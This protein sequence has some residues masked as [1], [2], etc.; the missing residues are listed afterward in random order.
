MNG[1]GKTPIK[2]GTDGWRGIIADD[3]TFENVRLCAQATADYLAAQNSGDRVVTV[4]YDTRF[5]SAG[6][7][8]AVC[9]VLAG[10]G[11]KCLL[12]ES[13]CPT[14]ALSLATAYN[15]ASAGIVITASHNPANWNGFKL[16]SPDGSSASGDMVASVEHQVELNLEE[17]SVKEVLYE[18]AA[19]SGLINVTDFKTPYLERLGEMV[20]LESIKASKLKIFYDAMY[21][22]GTGYLDR[23]I[24]G[25]NLEFTP[26]NN[27]VNPAFPG[28]IQPEPIARNLEKLS[29][30]VNQSGASAGLATDGDADRLGVV[31]E[32][33]VFL[34]TLQVYALLVLYLLEIK[35]ERGAIVRTI[36]SSSMLD[37][38]GEMYGVPVIEVPVGFKY[39][40]PV[41]IK[42]NAMVGGEESGGYGYRGHVPERDGILSALYFLDLMAR[43]G[44]APSGLLRLLFSKVGAHYYDRV[45]IEYPQGARDEIYAR[46]QKFEPQEL[47]G[48][49]IAGK[50]NLDGFRFRLEDGS[51]L[52]VRFSGTEPL[53][54]IYS[55]AGTR[56]RVERLLKIGREITHLKGMEF[57]T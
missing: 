15:H 18:N 8:R 27:S 26:I 9:E 3:F 30:L 50:D 44:L 47:D 6:F 12:A 38:L 46:V 1:S 20:D 14:P 49:R 21:G 11:I 52:L 24:S 51:W 33:G 29:T 39:V 36:T 48:V 57:E 28:M 45:D 53:L 37:R 35:Q 34:N 2:F 56:Q 19:S 10:N 5:A 42:E 16:K 4:G 7:A 22:A 32:S 25:G 40:A 31:D 41:M 55:E 17:K 13:F 23:L 54:R 43:T